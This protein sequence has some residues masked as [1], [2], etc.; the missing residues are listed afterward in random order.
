MSP[1]YVSLG[2]LEP[3]EA[4]SPQPSSPAFA[5]PAFAPPPEPVQ[6]IFQTANPAQVSISLKRNN[7]INEESNHWFFDSTEF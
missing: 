4:S 3:I 2:A 5:S 7:I 1:I 6:S